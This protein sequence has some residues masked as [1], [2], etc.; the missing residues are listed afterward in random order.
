MLFYKLLVKKEFKFLFKSNE[1]VC[2]R[3]IFI[4]PLL[5]DLY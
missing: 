5:R 2:R 1:V 4:N 3:M